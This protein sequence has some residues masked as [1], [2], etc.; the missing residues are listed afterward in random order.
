M[1]TGMRT[2]SKTKPK[3]LEYQLVSWYDALYHTSQTQILNRKK[4]P[5]YLFKNNGMNQ[6]VIEQTC[7]HYN[8]VYETF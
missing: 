7:C 2:E 8:N 4:N 5:T 1:F 3:S 6:W